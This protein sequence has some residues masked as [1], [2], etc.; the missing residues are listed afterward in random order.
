MQSRL[1]STLAPE[2]RDQ[3]DALVTMDRKLHAVKAIRD[4][5]DAASR[6]GLYE[7]LD[8]VVERYAV[9]GKRFQRSPTA[10][11]DLEVLAAKVQA[12]PHRPAAIE[13]VW[14]GD[15]EGW[16]VL[17]LA[18]TLDPRAE[19]HLALVQHGTDLRLFNGSVPPWPETEEAS[20]VGQALAERLGVPFHFASAEKPD[21]EAPRWWDAP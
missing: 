15:S 8:L 20:T 18:I 1:W 2:L 7:C 11:L 13:A 5:V 6:P 4:G 14:D 9:L 16:F 12:L 21:D 10:P 3:V 19:H 17:L